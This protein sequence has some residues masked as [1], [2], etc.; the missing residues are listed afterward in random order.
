MQLEIAI[1]L[2]LAIG[3]FVYLAYCQTKQDINYF[4]V[5]G[6]GQVTSDRQTDRQTDRQKAMHKSPACRS[7]GVLKKVLYINI[8]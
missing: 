3:G 4:L 8:Q 2:S 6:F 1:M 7:T 5:L